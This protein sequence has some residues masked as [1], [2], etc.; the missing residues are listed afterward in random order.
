MPENS[1]NFKNNIKKSKGYQQHFCCISLAPFSLGI[2]SLQFVNYILALPTINFKSSFVEKQIMFN[3][4]KFALCFLCIFHYFQHCFNLSYSSSTVLVPNTIS[5]SLII[6]IGIRSILY[7]SA[8]QGYSLAS[9][10][11]AST[12]GDSA[13]IR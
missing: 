9:I 5:F 1:N 3:Y 2:F 11:R 6:V 12:I 7:C 13:A 8:S 10:M 4:I